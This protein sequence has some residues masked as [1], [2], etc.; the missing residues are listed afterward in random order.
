M[1]ARR[2]P[3]LTSFLFGRETFLTRLF[4]NNRITKSYLMLDELAR[5]EPFEVDW[6]GSTCMLIRREILESGCFMD[7]GFFFTGLTLTTAA[8]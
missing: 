7:E 6:A 5:S 8:D 1:S 4:P 3:T 2:F